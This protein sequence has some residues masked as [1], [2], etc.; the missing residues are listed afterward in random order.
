LGGV[1]NRALAACVG[2]LCANACYTQALRLACLGR[3]SLPEPPTAQNIAFEIQVASYW[4]S[5]VHVIADVCHGP[6]LKCDPDGA[7][8]VESGA[9]AVLHYTWSNATQTR[10]YVRVRGEDI[11]TSLM[12]EDLPILP[13]HRL[14]LAVLSRETFA[15]LHTALAIA[16]D[17]ELG[18]LNA[19]A[20]DC[21]VQRA[22]GVRLR[23][24]QDGRPAAAAGIA[25]YF[26]GEQPVADTGSLTTREPTFVAGFAR[27]A[28]GVYDVIAELAGVELGRA[29]SIVVLPGVSTQ[30]SI[31]PIDRSEAR[32]LEPQRAHSPTD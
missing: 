30:T 11:Q 16:P 12:F 31:M 5:S 22:A 1:E 17:P 24:E 14:P 28:P 9:S 25:F 19:V 27:L 15:V 26:S 20:F 23:L 8:E 4:S 32:S 6:G 21:A 18:T 3:Y 7:V 13:D 29:R 10:P 2:S